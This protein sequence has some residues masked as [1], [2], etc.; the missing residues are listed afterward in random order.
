MQA[1]KL[2][3]GQTVA[4]THLAQNSVYVILYGLFGKI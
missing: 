2:D 3:H 4:R 1:V